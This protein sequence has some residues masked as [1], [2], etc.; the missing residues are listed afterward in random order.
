MLS[1]YT[2]HDLLQGLAEFVRSNRLALNV[3]RDELSQRSGVGIATLA[4]IEKSGICSTENLAKVLAA[5]GRIDALVAA[6][7]PE[8]EVGSIAELR[9]RALGGKRLRKRARKTP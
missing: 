6:L 3:T 5:L 1:L 9:A 7:A 2:P 8:E 4:R